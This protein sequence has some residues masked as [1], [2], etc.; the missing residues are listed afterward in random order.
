MWKSCD[1]SKQKDS[2]KACYGDICNI[3]TEPRT[4][5]KQKHLQ[6]RREISFFSASYDMPRDQWQNDFTVA[7][8]LML[9]G[10][11]KKVVGGQEMASSLVLPPLSSL[12]LCAS[13][14]NISNIIN[15]SSYLSLL[16]LTA[17][18]NK[19]RQGKKALM[20]T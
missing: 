5:E 14:A 20:C 13:G 19:V 8:V 16:L 2:S 1:N 7:A 17:H 6:D 18:S 3:W 15:A 4:K 12:L 10:D 9:Q 11:R